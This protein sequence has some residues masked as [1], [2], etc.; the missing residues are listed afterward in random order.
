VNLSVL[1][2]W[3][4]LL[5]S[6]ENYPLEQHFVKLAEKY[7]GR[8]FLTMGNKDIAEAVQWIGDYFTWLYPPEDKTTLDDILEMAQVVHDSE[9][10]GLK[11]FVLD[12]WNELDH[13]RPSNLSET[14][15]I[16]QALSKIRRFA[17]KNNIH[18]WIVAH[19]TKLQKDRDTGKYNPP[20]PYEIS[21]SAN[22]RNKADYCLTIHRPDMDYN[23]V[24]VIVNKVK[25]KSFGKLGTGELDYDFASGRFKDPDDV[26]Y[27]L[28]KAQ[29]SEVPF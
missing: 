12:P 16:S 11:G 21:G 27:E 14:E 28:P 25:F 10:Q 24:Q 5:F 3:K 23:K 13:R 6:P 2:G 7:I 9:V 17:R 19:P 26:R 1:Y 8:H 4:H 18:V 15:Y 29:D 20:T 22:W